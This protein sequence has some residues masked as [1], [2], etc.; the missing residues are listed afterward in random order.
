MILFNPYGIF[1]TNTGYMV[2]FPKS[3]INIGLKITGKR[4]DGYHDI[5]TVFYPVNF[6]D[7]IEYVINNDKS[8]TD[9]ITVTGLSIP[10]DYHNNLV[11]KAVR[12]LRNLFDLPYLRIHLHKVIPAGAGLGGGSSD[13]AAVLRM[14]NRHFGLAMTL[15]DLKTIALE[16]GSDCPFFIEGV[17]SLASGR[18]EV[19][20]P[21][22]HVL[23]SMYIVL[24]NPGIKISTKD[25][26]NNCI[27]SDR[28]PG[29]GELIKRP[30]SEWRDL[31]INDF[32]KII[33]KKHPDI[34]A[35]KDRLYT[36]G[37]IY[38]SMSGSGSTVYGIFRE[39]PSVPDDL[40]KYL[41]YEGEL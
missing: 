7:C 11:L 4:N 15:H 25:A 36:A 13:A 10:G 24:L 12:K 18:G 40:E 16:I 39:K 33:F 3:K 34:G 2:G 21:V 38:S 19:L 22:S 17:P 35:L 37:A 30:V 14:M 5:E 28:G 23:E 31:I 29:P 1:V 6:Y 32:E 26:Y 20:M 27:P 9:V 41:V 8:N